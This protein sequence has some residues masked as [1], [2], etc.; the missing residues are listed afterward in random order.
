M[1]D[2]LLAVMMLLLFV[3][4]YFAV[5][6]FGQYMDECFQRNREPEESDRRLIITETEGRS[7]KEVSEEISAM[8]DSLQNGTDSA[9]IICK[10]MNPDIIECLRSS[11]CVVKYSI[12]Q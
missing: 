12:R 10:T 2:I 4:S 8:F 1:E 11:G 6:R 3:F 7:A 9:F 5:A